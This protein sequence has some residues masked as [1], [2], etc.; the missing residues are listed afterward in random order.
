MI[1][2][3]VLLINLSG[4]PFND[5]DRKVIKNAKEGCSKYYKD[6]PCLKQFIKKEKLVYSAICGPKSSSK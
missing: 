3:A 5:F 6:N 1:C 4:I 2:A